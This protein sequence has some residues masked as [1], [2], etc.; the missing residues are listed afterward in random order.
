MFSR[1]LHVFGV[2]QKLSILVSLWTMV[3]LE[4]H[5]IHLGLFVII[6]TKDSKTDQIFCTFFFYG[7][8]I[9]HYSDGAASLTDLCHTNVIGN[10]V[11]IKVTKVAV[12]FYKAQMIFVLVLLILKSDNKA[13]CV[14]AIIAN[15]I[16]V[17]DVLLYHDASRSIR[18]CIDWAIIL[19]DC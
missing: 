5:L 1:R 7:N 9:Y 11:H 14:V 4:W 19:T 12:E 13:E 15:E 18:S 8:C 6:F 3:L 16:V 2:E 10:I 17:V